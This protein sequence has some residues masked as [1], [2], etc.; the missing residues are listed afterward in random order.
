MRPAFHKKIEKSDGQPSKE[1]ETLDD[2]RMEEDGDII[3][4]FTN[5]TVDG[6]RCCKRKSI[7]KKAKKNSKAIDLATLTPVNERCRCAQLF[8]SS[9]AA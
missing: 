1:E 3:I 8:V 6:Q 2:V 5:P 9:C 7:A 4:H